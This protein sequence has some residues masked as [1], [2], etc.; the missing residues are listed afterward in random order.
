[1]KYGCWCYNF[2]KRL[3]CNNY[4]ENKNSIFSKKNERKFLSVFQFLE[5]KLEF[6]SRFLYRLCGFCF[7]FECHFTFG[8]IRLTT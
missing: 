1:M 6:Y 7:Y 5:K 8:K 4:L 3:P 2:E